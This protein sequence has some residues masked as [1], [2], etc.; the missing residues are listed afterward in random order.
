MLKMNLVPSEDF[1]TWSEINDVDLTIYFAETGADREMDF[2]R[3][4]E[5]REIFEKCGYAAVEIPS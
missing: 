2:D 5:E 4:K 1:E 3:E